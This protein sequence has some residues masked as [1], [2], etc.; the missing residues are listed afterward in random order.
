MLNRTKTEEYLRERELPEETKTYAVISHG[1]IIDKIRDY[2]AEKNFVIKEELYK[3][4]DGGDVAMGFMHIENQKDP[5]MGMT[6][7]WTNSYNKKL[8]FSCAIGGFIY[9]NSVPFISSDSKSRYGRIHKGTALSD[10][11]DV[12]EQMI[13]Q[14]EDH[15]DK[16]IE[17]KNKFKNIAV[18]RKEYAKLMGLLYFDKEVFTSEQVNI[19]RREYKNPS[20]KYSEDGPA[21]G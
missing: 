3:A 10:V 18:S 12:I 4:M 8:R 15:F 6:F 9:D 21:W 11:I 7:N 19:V 5:D 2:L 16:I 14:S 13:E 20:F 17:M 1:F